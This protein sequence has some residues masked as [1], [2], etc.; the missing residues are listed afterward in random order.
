MLRWMDHHEPFNATVLYMCAVLNGS[1]STDVSIR[2]RWRKTIILQPLQKWKQK[3]AEF[4]SFKH[5][6]KEIILIISSYN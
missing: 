4:A 6:Q 5:D 2:E 3:I 1:L